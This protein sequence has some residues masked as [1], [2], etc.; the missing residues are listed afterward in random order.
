MSKV[1]WLFAIAGLSVMLV[2]GMHLISHGSAVAAEAQL[3]KIQPVG[4]VVERDVTLAGKLTAIKLDPQTLH[5]KKNTI[6][7][8][9]NGVLGQEVKVIFEE[10]KACKDV[11][12][13]PMGFSL[14]RETSCY[15]TSF[16]PYAATSSLQ[17]S[18]PGTLKYTVETADAKIKAKGEIIVK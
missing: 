4:E 3:V 18:Q 10:G 12:V 5:I 15:V 11:T 6:V 7:V 9:L 8:W 16:I 13:N 2:M 1:K 14:D 17:F